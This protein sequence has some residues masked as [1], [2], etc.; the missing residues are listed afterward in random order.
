MKL[1]KKED[2]SVVIS[3]KERTKHPWKELQRQSME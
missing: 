2:H 3:E 1:K